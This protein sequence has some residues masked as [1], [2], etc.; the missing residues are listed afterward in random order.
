MAIFYLED[1]TNY[2]FR[3]RNLL[4]NSAF[5]NR[6]FSPLQER[7]IDLYIERNSNQKLGDIF[8][9][10]EQSKAVKLVSTAKATRAREFANIPNE[11]IEHFNTLEKKSKLL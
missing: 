6:V 9:Q 11:I 5:I 4:Q 2:L 1:A 8:R 3:Q 10:F 7:L